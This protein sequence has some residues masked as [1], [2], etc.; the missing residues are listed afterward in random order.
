MDSKGHVGLRR[1]EPAGSNAQ[2]PAGSTLGT[3]AGTAGPST[4]SRPVLPPMQTAGMGKLTPEKAAELMQN[5]LKELPLGMGASFV[6]G[7]KGLTKVEQ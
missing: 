1:K 5:A 3:A 7:L 6:E 4:A 2:F